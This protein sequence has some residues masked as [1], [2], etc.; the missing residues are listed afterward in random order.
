MENKEE[1]VL[2]ISKIAIKSETFCTVWDGNLYC[3]DI[4]E[5]AEERS[6]W[7]YRSNNSVKML[8]WGEEVTNDRDE[9]LDCVFSNIPDYVEDYE[10]EY[11]EG[12]AL[13]EKLDAIYERTMRN[14]HFY[15]DEGKNRHLLNEIGVLRGISYCLDEVMHG[16]F[17]YD[18]DFIKMIGKQNRLLGK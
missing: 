6:A 3:I 12:A 10:E 11:G 4:C 1:I 16:N 15:K 17:A 7:L 13:I 8:M 14:C 5:D 2:K 18:D 9:F